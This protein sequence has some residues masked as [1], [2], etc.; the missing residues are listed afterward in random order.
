MRILL[1]G[2]TGFIGSHVARQLAGLGHEVCV[3][4]RGITRP[5]VPVTE[6][7]GDRNDLRPHVERFRALRPD[8]VVDFVLSDGKQAE[9]LVEAFCSLT[10]RIIAISSGDVYRACGILHG[11]ESGPLQP[12]PLTEESELRTSRNVYS[13]EALSHLRS[14]FPWLGD[15]Y[16]KI[17]VEHVVMNTPGLE[18]T[19]L[20]LPMVYGPG[21]PLHRLFPYLKRMDDKRPAI[22]LQDDTAR[23]RGPRG[24]VENVAAAIVLATVS[25]SAAGRIY[26][27]GGQ[28]TLCEADWVREIGSVAHWNGAV[29]AFSKDAL[30]PHLRVPYRSEQHWEM[31]SARIR[32]EL[33]YKEPVDFTAAL[34]RTIAWERANPPSQ[35]DPKQFDYAAEDAALVLRCGRKRMNSPPSRSGFC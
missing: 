20:R 28:E 14:I 27:V 8:A 15:E 12:V 29:V 9:Q 5:P 35:I 16:D 21:D 22:L 6:I 30:P 2:A 17:P 31:S 18:G 26:N 32:K 33:G 24:Y 7:V 34:E 1:I 25:N 11:F 10:A 13:S 23:W 3:F 4:H 19:I